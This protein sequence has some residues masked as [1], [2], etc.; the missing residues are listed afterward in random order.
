MS[1]YLHNSL[2][3]TE[4]WLPLHLLTEYYMEDKDYYTRK[5]P[6]VSFNGLDDG[7]H[8]IEANNCRNSTNPLEFV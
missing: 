8:V 6:T 1:D 3:T 2:S 4:L 5:K 7:R